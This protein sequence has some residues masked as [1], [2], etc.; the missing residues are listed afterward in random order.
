MARAGD[1]DGVRELMQSATTSNG[2]RLYTRQE[3]RARARGMGQT[4]VDKLERY[5]ARH[6]GFAGSQSK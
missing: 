5:E 4:A 1:S 6:P 2:D 3:I